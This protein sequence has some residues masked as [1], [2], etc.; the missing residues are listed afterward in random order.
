MAIAATTI[1]N[2]RTDGDDTCGAGFNPDN[3]NM[4]TDLAA[5]VATGN[6]PV[7]TSAT[8]TFVAGD[9]GKHLFIKS[10]TNWTPGWYVISSV[11][12]GAATIQATVGTVTLYSSSAPIN[13]LN[14]VAGC[15]TVAS[16]TSG[17]F[18]ID[19]SRST[20][21]A[22]SLSDG[23]CLTAATNLTSAT[24]GFTKAM[25][26]NLLYSTG[27]GTNDITGYLEI[28]NHTDTNTVVIDRTA[29]SGG[30]ATGITFKVGGGA[31]SPG[32]VSGSKVAGN[33]ILV[34]GGDDPEA[35]PF[36]I[37]NSADVSG[38]RIS[39]GAGM[40]FHL[41][42]YGTLPG[43]ITTVGSTARPVL[44]A[45]ANSV[46]ILTN[47][48]NT[49]TIAEN[50][51]L[52]GNKA[53]YTGT[54][55]SSGNN[56]WVARNC[57]A[58][59]GASGGFLGGGLAATDCDAHSNTGAGFPFCRS[60]VRCVARDNSTNGFFG[61]TTM[62]DCV[63]VDNTQDGMNVNNTMVSMSGC[64]CANN[65]GDGADF[66]AS[67]SSCII[68]NCIFYGNGNYGI[69]SAAASGARLRAF[70]CAFGS[71]TSGAT[72]GPVELNGTVTLT[73]TPFTN[74]ASDDYSLNNTTGGGASCRAA[75]IPSA[76]AGLSSTP[77]YRDLGA[78][79]SQ[80]GTG[81]AGGADII[82]G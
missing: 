67:M 22:L 69:R 77:N 15:A 39:W 28:V 62:V 76:F 29:A 43:D 63:A 16:P 79:Q 68:D 13:G 74:S 14:T 30:D 7:C 34:R 47:S 59:N 49:N 65:G 60:L 1:W 35:N 5:T 12:G 57:T 48:S 50:L 55:A 66:G 27:A 51:I 64:T 44:K 41:L 32:M 75:G 23:A 6:A 19:Y 61:A 8:Y 71:N 11:A 81:S 53:T 72:T 70:N 73:A 18:S 36:N 20:T 2:A 21:A 56:Y 9:V 58:R 40:H 26:G 31:A 33:I 54:A 37:S 52:D 42:G 46:A 17:T 80:Y 45:A 24:G 82:G 4:M 3:A 25:I 78:A 38:G 10:G